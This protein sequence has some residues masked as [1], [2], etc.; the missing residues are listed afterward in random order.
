MKKK[1][2]VRRKWRKEEDIEKGNGEEK[3]EREE[4]KEAEENKKNDENKEIR[5]EEREV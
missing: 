4:E 2:K 5:G 1:E 3:E